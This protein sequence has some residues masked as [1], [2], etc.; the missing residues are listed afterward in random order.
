MV[1]GKV[2]IGVLIGAVAISTSA[3]AQEARRLDIGLH[4]EVEHNTNVTRS[5][6][7]QSNVRGLTP[8]DTTFRPTATVDF[9]T[10]I[11]RQ[12]VFLSGAAG[13]TFY[14]K[15]T[16]LNRERLDF[17]GGVR[18]QVSLCGATLTGGYSRGVGEIDDPTLV[19]NVE[20]IQETKRA[21]VDVTCSRGTGFGAVASASKTWVDNSLTTSEPSNSERSSMMVG[22]TYA[23]PTL[24]SLTLFVNRDETSYPNRLIDDGYTM[25]AYGVTY[26]R[27]LGARIQGSV[28]VSYN[29]V[30]QKAPPF[31]PVSGGSSETSAYSGFLTYRAS[32]RLNL[33]T[34]FSRSITPSSAFGRS[35][36]LSEAYRLSA[37]YSLGSRII[38]TAGGSWVERNSEGLILVG[39]LILTDSKTKTIYG[40]IRYKQNDRLSFVLNAGREDRTTNSPQFDYINDRIGL[41]ADV[42]F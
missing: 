12:E 32:S 16:R 42:T 6:K 39:P 36:D 7:A 25:D 28:T 9:S 33:R 38:I 41:S 18:G 21:G 31:L 13:Y 40:N 26:S 10:P 24:G 14:D 4:A 27:Q 22:A 8:A 29:K 2:A 34:S 35:Y 15:N 20:N 3:T 37:D 1:Y 17:N 11:G 30:D 5:S 19:E 23:R